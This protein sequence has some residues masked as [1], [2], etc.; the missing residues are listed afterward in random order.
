M[1]SLKIYKIKIPLLNAFTTSFDTTVFKIG[2]VL[3]LTDADTEAYSECVTDENP[4]Y[5]Y[6][7][8]FTSLHIIKDHLSELISDLPDPDIF[9]KRASRIKGHNMAKAAIEMLLWDLKSK[10]ENI[11]LYKALGDSKNFADVGISIGIDEAPVMLSRVEKAL[12][13]GYKRIKV[14]ISR[15]KELSIISTIRDTYPE[16]PLSVDANSDYTLSDLDTLKKLDRYNLLY[17]EQP[18]S[19][20]DLIDHSILRKNISTPICLD[21]SITSPE[22]AIKAF[23]IGATDIINIKPGRVGGLYNSLSIAKIA[24]EHD[25]H[26][27]VGG[28]LETG[29][30]R[31][32]NISLAATKLIDFPGDTSPNSRYFSRDLVTNPFTM[33]NGRISPNN[34]PGIGVEIDREQLNKVTIFSENIF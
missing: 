22:N 20:D 26:A 17:L 24:R 25:G 23:E 27:W 14:K 11:P 6:E 18:L 33:V 8:N 30:G 28:M 16:I 2:H 12:A 13:E 7:D 15:G 5:S 9:M 19:H 3:V 34:A 29:I 1:A 4:Y 31:A 32:F 10:Q 21:E